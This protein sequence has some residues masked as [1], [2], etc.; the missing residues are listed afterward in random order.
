MPPINITQILDK[1]R[2]A[3]DIMADLK[4]K[5]VSVPTWETLK[6]EYDTRLHPVMNKAI[7][8]DIVKDDGIE[9]V[10]RITLG[11][12]KLAAKRMT[13]LCF[14]IPVRRS[15][16]IDRDNE[17]QKRAAKAIEQIYKKNRID[18]INIDRGKYL[19]AGCELIT[20][21]YG[22]PNPDKKKTTIY[23]EESDMKIR[24]ATYSPM[25]GDS[26]F[27]L[28]DE[29]GD[30]IA[31]SIEYRRSIDGTDKTAAFMDTYTTDRHIRFTDQ[32]TD[33]G[34]SWH[35]EDDEAISIGKIPGVYLSRPEPIWEDEARNI[36]EMEWALSRNGNYIRKNSKP[37]FMLMADE[38]NQGANKETQ[39][40]E[41]VILQYP[42]GSDG[43]YITWDQAIDSLKFHVQTLRS[44]F[45]T[46]LQ[47]PDNSFEVMKTTP[48]SGEARKM[49]FIDAQLKVI[50]EAG[51][52]LEFF[53][54]EVN[55]IRAFAAIMFPD[56]KTEIEEIEIET[57]IT[58]FKID[59]ET[60]NITNASLAAGGKAIA[61][62]RTFVQRLGW[63]E[64]VD[65]ELQDI[66]ADEAENA[67]GN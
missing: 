54:R 67:L 35:I 7:Y 56:L 30:M 18:A 41:R 4:K 3:A 40:S 15:Y 8:P 45:F 2:P 66:A 57:I 43:K 64:D 14:G 26:L 47:L 28:F 12:P 59:D 65:Q 52:L 22:V 42:K 20:I 10:T 29:Y 34:T 24:C 16:K 62:R 23:G 46:S 50:D 33:K 25:N 48:V 13:E 1:T 44:N 17:K 5:T 55:V 21:W 63:T 39:N 31:L 51:R 38:E 9:Y 19:F 49:M 36:Y 27:P 58:P 61:S 60:E 53:D 37:I 6:S 11:F 32:D